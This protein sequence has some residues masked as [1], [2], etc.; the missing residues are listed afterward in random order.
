[1]EGERLGGVPSD[2]AGS[3]EPS[4]LVPM[5]EFVAF[6]ER[7]APD[8][9][10]YFA[11]RTFDP[12]AAADLTAETFAQAFASRHRFSDRGRGSA[13]AWLYTI[14][15]HQLNRFYR[16]GQADH[17]MRR[18]LGLPE[19]PLSVDDYDRI[20]Q[21]IDFEVIGRSVAAALSSLSGAQRDAV[22]ARVIEGCSFQEV[23]RRLGCSEQTARA[24][25]SRG[26]R[27]LSSLLEPPVEVGP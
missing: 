14:A 22:I 13:E 7:S 23:A 5:E 18:R 17:R 6:Y 12:E 24:R 15:R 21:L 26:L 27:R 1:M 4:P 11:R 9:L 8:L 19:R 16:K 10:T 25:V 3:T 20:E 2:E